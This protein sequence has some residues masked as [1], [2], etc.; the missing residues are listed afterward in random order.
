MKKREK[1]INPLREYDCK[2]VRKPLA[3]LNW[4]FACISATFI[5]LPF[6]FTGGMLDFSFTDFLLLVIYSSLPSAVGVLFFA[7]PNIAYR[8]I[9]K[10]VMDKSFEFEKLMPWKT[11]ELLLLKLKTIISVTFKYWRYWLYILIICLSVM[12]ISETL[13]NGDILERIRHFLRFGLEPLTEILLWLIWL[14]LAWE[15]LALLQIDSAL[16]GYA[17]VTLIAI[18]LF[19]MV[20]LILYVILYFY[21]TFEIDRRWNYSDYGAD[22]GSNFGDLIISIA[23]FIGLAQLIFTR[24]SRRMGAVK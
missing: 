16:S 15:V 23:I 17:L 21:L 12:F 11:N 5:L 1:Y 6:I 18:Q 19:Y 24:V 2:S 13:S 20:V 7:V 22:S 3:V 4:V 14:I 10:R 9:S 8:T